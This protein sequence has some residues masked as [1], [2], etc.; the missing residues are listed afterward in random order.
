MKTQRPSPD[1][2]DRHVAE[3]LP[4]EPQAPRKP[5]SATTQEMSRAEILAFLEAQRNAEKKTP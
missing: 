1:R 4:E 3:H 2:E 5:S